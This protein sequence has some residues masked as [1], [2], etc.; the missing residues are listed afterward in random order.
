MKVL[1]TGINGQLGYDLS[2][3]L[4]SRCIE[5]LG[6]DRDKLD[7]S[8]E[9]QVD[10]V[11]CSY[12]PDVVIHCAAYTAVDK[13][14]E[15]KE[16]CYAVNVLG[17]RYIAR[18]CKKINAKMF[19]ISTDYVFD[20]Q[21][22]LVFDTEDIPNPINYYGKTKYEAELEVQSQLEKYFVI[23]TSWVFG[24]HGN[25]FVKTM[26]RLGKNLD[27]IS[28]VADQIGS[29]TYT[30]DLAKL[31]VDMMYSEKY[32]IYHATNEG[33]C[34]WHD[35]ACAIFKYTGMNVKVNAITTDQYTTNALRPKN[36]R[37]SKNKLPYRLRR[38]EEA[39][40]EYLKNCIQY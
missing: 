14:E 11:I 25:N 7:I 15:H 16:L 33:F 13:A 26:L 32:G 9:N 30:Y 40:E 22:D 31:L 20:G 37:L 28:V 34:S 4:E 35:F 19:F 3:R 38:W 12:K 5:Y 21:G 2:Q 29:P 27:E 23:R 18:A 36:S 10:S 24:S 17:T 8:K 39:L 6:T 1:V